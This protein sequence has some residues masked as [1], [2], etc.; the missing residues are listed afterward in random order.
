MPDTKGISRLPYDENDPEARFTECASDL[1]SEQEAI[2]LCML[3]QQGVDL[4]SMDS[5]QESWQESEQHEKYE[6]RIGRVKGKVTS[7]V[8]AE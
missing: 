1:G 3:V 4:A 8:F 7:I 2:D 5:I 6:F